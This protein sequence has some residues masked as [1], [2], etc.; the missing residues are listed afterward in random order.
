MGRFQDDQIENG[1]LLFREEGKSDYTYEDYISDEAD[2]RWKEEQ[3][4]R[5]RDDRR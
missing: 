2:R 3:E 5:L 1:M 4:A